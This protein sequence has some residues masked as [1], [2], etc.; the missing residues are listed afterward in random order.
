MKNYRNLSSLALL[1]YLLALL[2]CKKNDVD[3]SPPLNDN[4]L[5]SASVSGISII[6]KE[7]NQVS[8][9]M[10]VAVFKDSRNMEYHFNSSHFF[11]DTITLS[12]GPYAFANTGISLTSAGQAG[13]YSALMLLDQSG[14]ILTT[15]PNDHRIS[16]AKTFATNLG[17]SNETW[18]WSFS[19]SDY[20]RH[21]DAFTRDTSVLI[22]QIENLSN[23]EAGGTPLYFSQ[24]NAIQA[25][26]DKG[27]NANKALL[28]F[29]DGEDTRGGYTSK[30]VSDFAVSKNVRLFN[31]GLGTS[32]PS[33]LL[34]QSIDGKG[35]FMYAKDAKQ[36]ISMFGNLGKLLDQS[37]RFYNINWKV[38]TTGAGKFTTGTFFTNL[39]IKTPYNYTIVIPLQIRY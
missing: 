35:A 31:I 28:T 25:T 39:R 18:L 23:K 20:A 14:S 21:G 7:E 13:N 9:S 3:F 38:T 22:P 33:S 34:Q 11:I 27:A 6:S 24:Y 5:P 32:I 8:F 1:I 15:D 2:S 17:N 12:G 30:Q 26:S 10:Q 36:L 37:A 29:T 19:G 16:A 4:S